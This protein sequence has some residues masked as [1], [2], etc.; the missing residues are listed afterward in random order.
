MRFGI[1]WLVGWLP[2]RGAQV[3]GRSAAAFHGHDSAGIEDKGW[4]GHGPAVLARLARR[5]RRWD[6]G[7][8]AQSP[9]SGWV[10]RTLGRCETLSNQA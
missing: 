8:G 6:E 4:T 5:A 9:H 1:E 10:A 3:P 7:L 2:V